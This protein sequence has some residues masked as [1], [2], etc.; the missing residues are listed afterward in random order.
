MMH[1]QDKLLCLRNGGK[2]AAR[3]IGQEKKEGGMGDSDVLR[4]LSLLK[5]KFGIAMSYGDS[6]KPE[7]GEEL[8]GIDRELGQLRAAIDAEH[9]KR[10]RRKQDAEARKH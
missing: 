8:E 2:E 6:W 3:Q 5:R 4:Y 9:E 10:D 7:Y 1:K